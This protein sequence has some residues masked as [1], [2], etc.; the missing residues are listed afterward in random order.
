MQEKANKIIEYEKEQEKIHIGDVVTVDGCNCIVLDVY[1]NGN[2]LS[3][4][5]KSGAVV[6]LHKSCATKTGKHYPI[7]KMLKEL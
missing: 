7:D 1:D 5:T 6:T 3:V 2:T 4:I